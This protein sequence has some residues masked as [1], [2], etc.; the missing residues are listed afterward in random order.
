MKESNSKRHDHFLHP[1]IFVLKEGEGIQKDF[2]DYRLLLLQVGQPDVLSSPNKVKSTPLAAS[3][4][5]F[6]R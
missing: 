5:F 1:Y 6:K 2:L 4:Q 3:I